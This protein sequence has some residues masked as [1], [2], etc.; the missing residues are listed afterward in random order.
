MIELSNTIVKRSPVSNKSKH[1]D[2]T[3]LL[4][5][6]AEMHYLDGKNQNEIAQEIGMTRSNVSRLLKEAREKNIVKIQVIHPVQENDLLSQELVTRFELIDAHVIQVHQTK[7]LL[8]TLGK[9]AGKEL[10]K[11]L[12]PDISLGTTWGTAV[13]ATIDQLEITNRIPNIKVVQLLGAV[14]SR[15][16]VYDGHGIVRRLEEILDAEGIYINAPYFVE[17]ATAAE[18]LL[19]TPSIKES[20]NACKEVDV[21]LLGVGSLDFSHCSYYLA[22]YMPEHELLEIQKTG[23][24]GDVSG[25]F[26]NINGEKVAQSYQDRLI[27]IPFEDLLKIPIRIGVAGGREKI[28]PIIGALRGKLINVLI[29]DSDTAMEVL[30]K[31]NHLSINNFKAGDYG[32]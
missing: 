9:V 28:D 5:R 26:Y 17:S 24:I 7:Q 19:R 22:G 2:R 32:I 29:T 21:A 3:I 20:I 16:Q 10:T 8:H 13:S 14:G 6:I 4:A 12:E 23:A 31:T 18:L 1:R 25:R 27:G 11:Y 15:I 30:E